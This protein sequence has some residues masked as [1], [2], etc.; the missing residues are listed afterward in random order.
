MGKVV[1][2]S[3][4]QGGAKKIQRGGGERAPGLA[5]TQREDSLWVKWMA[6]NAVCRIKIRLRR[7]ESTG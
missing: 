3:R 5:G 2:S 6:E 4:I 7:K 1:T